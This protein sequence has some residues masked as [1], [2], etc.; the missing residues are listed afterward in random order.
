ML[1]WRATAQSGELADGEENVLPVLPN[2]M[3]VTESLPVFTRGQGDR[4]F[5]FEKLKQAGKSPTLQHQSLTVEFTSN[6]AWYAIQALPYLMEY[7]WECAEQTWGR[8]YANA[9]A[10]HI[11]RSSPRVAQVFSKWKSLDT[12][13]L[14]SSLAKNQ[15][16][17]ALLLE[18]TPWVLT[19][20]SE[21]AQKKNIA[22]L[23]DLVRMGNEQERALAKL[24]EMQTPNGGFPWFKGGADNRYITQYIVTGIGHLKKM[25]AFSPEQERQATIILDKALPYLDSRMQEDYASLL[26]GKVNL[27]ELTPGPQAIQY[28]YMRSF[29]PYKA[30]PAASNEAYQ[31]FFTR[32]KATWI[33]N[34]KMLQGMIALTMQRSRESQT[35]Q[36][37]LESLKQKA[38]HNEELG[39]YWKD[40]QRSWWWHEAPIERQALLIEVF[41]EISKDA[42]VVNDLKT[43]L[44]KSKQ[45]NNWE[46]TKATAEACYALL[47]QGSNWLAESPATTVHLGETEIGS[48]TDATESG[49][50][51]FKRALNAA[52]IKPDMG[53]IRVSVRASAAANE[54]PGWGAVY[55]QYFEDLDKITFAETPLKLS[56]QLFVE[57]NSDNG[58]VLTPVR[59][60]DA[61]KVGD[62]IKV[63]I[64]LRV[65]RDMEYVHMKDMRASGLEPVNVLSGYRW[66][67]GLGYYESTRDASTNFFFDALQKGTYVFEYPLFITHEGD[68]SNGITT[69][70]CMY[71]P[72]FTAHSEGVR[73]KALPRK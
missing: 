20:K 30:I 49:T 67:G 22:L 17:K 1:T 46:S 47:R 57:I 15:E 21:A 68:F 19:A 62:K 71:A 35:A 8:F 73:L 59:E 51:Y 6:P 7:P 72:E 37:I 3:L 60:G 52:A 31:L 13:A 45:T 32:A 50:G 66:Q 48:N 24:Q 41:E 29:F 69:I 38:I 42:S 26:R 33:N 61:V 43:W 58:P 28:L 39:M 34:S 14:Q 25:N 18:E 11:V 56:K 27:K 65:D 44:L 55:W 70:Q 16:L 40:S 53:D 2:R 54:L 23:F 4:T 63:R 36:D 12:T 9:I 10:A 5:T 64:E